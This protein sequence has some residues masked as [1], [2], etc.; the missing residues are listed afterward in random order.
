MAFGI[1]RQELLT[2]KTQVAN[3]QIA[4]LTHYWIHPKFPQ[5]HTVTKAGCRDIDLLITWGASYGLQP[6][7]IDRRPAYP[8]FDLI[9]DKQRE[10]LINEHLFDHIE[11]F[12]IF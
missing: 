11:R 5:Y 9:G 2:W 7:W 3:G 12:H 4:F 10:I 1:T 8:H 6:E